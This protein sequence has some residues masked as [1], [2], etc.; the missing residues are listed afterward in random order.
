M[1]LILIYLYQLS[2]NQQRNV[3]TNVTEALGLVANSARL[4]GT[5][6]EGRWNLPPERDVGPACNTHTQRK[7]RE[8]HP[9]LVGW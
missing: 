8:G 4:S 7:M 2:D 1:V 6:F 5:A 3:A 9:K